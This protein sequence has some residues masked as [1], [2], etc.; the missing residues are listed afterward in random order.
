MS[1]LPIKCAYERR[2]NPHAADAEA[3]YRSLIASLGLAD[4]DLAVISGRSQIVGAAALVY[5][6]ADRRTLL[7]AALWTACLIVNDDRWD[8]SSAADDR[9][10]PGQWF[11]GAAEVVDTWRTSPVRRDDAFFEL[12]RT[13]MVLLDESLGPQASQEI[14]DEIKRSIEAMKWEGVWNE[15]TGRTSLASYLS[16]RRCYS[17]MDVQIVLDK[18]INGGRSFAAID[19]HPV[20]RAIDD[21]VT[22]FGCLSNDYY[23][24]NREKR[25][26]D[27]SNSVKV[28]IDHAGYDEETAL[29]RVREECEQAMVDLDCIEESIKRSAHFGDLE[30]DLLD[31][32]ACHRPLIY[33]A[34]TWPTETDRYRWRSGRG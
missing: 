7:A 19:D 13:T 23:S 2:R 12:L 34:A 22:R 26:V 15:F 31:Y 20:R 16:L 10:T 8:N 1:L 29:A 28:L 9:L 6:E 33:A 17:T 18:W 32:A 24:W 11:A 25:A 27:K 5:P 4:A 14:G 3:D 30:A 21:V